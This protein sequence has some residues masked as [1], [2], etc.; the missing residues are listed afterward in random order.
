[1]KTTIELPDDLLERSKAV[2][3]RENS[4]LKALIEE[5]L[6]LALRSRARKRAAPFSVQPF[7]GDGL[8]PEFSATRWDQ[9]RDEIY[10]DR[11]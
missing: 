4:T 11:G 3:R 6:R 5:G 10:R 7:Q 8:T 2:A 9:V 1:M